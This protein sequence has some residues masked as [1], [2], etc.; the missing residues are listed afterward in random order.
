M[1]AKVFFPP[2]S[3]KNNLFVLHYS[4]FKLQGIQKVRSECTSSC[5][6]EEKLDTSYHGSLIKYLTKYHLY[7]LPI[8]S[9]MVLQLVR[10]MR[11]MKRKW[12]SMKLP[13]LCLLLVHPTLDFTS[14]FFFINPF[15]C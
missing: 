14:E 9:L 15:N 1:C 11:K 7:F 3:T 4:Y 12:I 10:V 13:M 6:L 8:F 2:R 5:K